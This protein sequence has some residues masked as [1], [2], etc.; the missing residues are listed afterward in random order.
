MVVQD[1]TTE[2]LANLLGLWQRLWH[3]YCNTIKR[4]KLDEPTRTILIS[5]RNQLKDC[6]D[7]LKAVLSGKPLP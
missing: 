1:S 6:I 7:E 4:G 2:Q 5:K 3:Q